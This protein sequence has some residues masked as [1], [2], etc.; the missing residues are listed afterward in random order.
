MSQQTS[1]SKRIAL[2]PQIGVLT[3]TRIAMNTSFRMVYPLLPIFTTELG[4]DVATFSIL[5]TVLQL[6]GLTAPVFGQL[7]E[8]EGRRFTMLFGVVMYTAGMLLVFVS[9]NFVGFASALIVA[10]L[11][12]IAFDPALQAYVGDRVPYERRG[13]YLGL[14]E[15]GWAGAYFIGVPIVSWLLATASWQAPFIALASVTGIL[16][17]VLFFMLDHD[18]PLERKQISFWRG[19]RMAINSPMAIAGLALGAGISGANQLVSV[20]F[21]LWI[22]DSFGIQLTALA[23]ASTVIGIS[24]LSGEGIVT[25]LSDRFGKRRMIILSILGNIVV[26]LLLPFA[27]ITLTIAL[28]GLFC[29]YLTF[30]IALVATI[31]LA[32]EL[33]PD[34]R[35]M[36]LTIFVSAVTLGRTIATPLSTTIYDFGL[37]ANTIGAIG[38]NLIALIAV[39]RFIRVQ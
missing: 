1:K 15:V 29:F 27:N 36:Y 19:L 20:V 37:L 30:E 10:S 6:L 5:L 14:L 35:G 28:I 22:A 8:R 21:G 12:K 7:S 33:N 23:I 9:P 17:I 38:F 39:W 34:A 26:C 18:K 25:I 32:S 24:E 31:P 3:L 16:L 13:F 4:V 2:L 11:G